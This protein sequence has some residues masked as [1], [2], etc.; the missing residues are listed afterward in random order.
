M[1]M[2]LPKQPR[3]AAGLLASGWLQWPPSSLLLG[4]DND[5][6]PT[7]SP[8]QL[9]QPAPKLSYPKP[10]CPGFQASPVDSRHTLLPKD[11]QSRSGI[12]SK[13]SGEVQCLNRSL[14]TVK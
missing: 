10:S 3:G 13:S 5:L 2:N 12:L 11:P 7:H 4:G 6:L 9:T 1:S 8:R 14:T